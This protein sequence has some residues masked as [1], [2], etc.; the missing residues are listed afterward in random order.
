MELNHRKVAI[1]TDQN[2]NFDRNFERQSYR[3][4]DITHHAF[5]P[6]DN[7]NSY[8][9]MHSD[10]NRYNNYNYSHSKEFYELPK[11]SEELYQQTPNGYPTPQGLHLPINEHST[12]SLPLPLTPYSIPTTGSAPTSPSV[13]YEVGAQQYMP[14]STS[15]DYQDQLISPYS[16]YPNSFQYPDSMQLTPTRMSMKDPKYCE[17]RRKNN[18]ASKKSRA[19]KK[20]KAKEMES[21][22]HVLEEE[23][24]QLRVRKNELEQD[25]AGYKQLIEKI[26]AADHMECNTAVIQAFHQ[27][28]E[29]QLG[30][31]IPE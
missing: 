16:Q 31:Q 17:R 6:L 18:E 8:L 20:E 25:L 4:L 3:G 7:N 13:G 11:H 19:K 10:A 27:R 1:F 14:T 26:Q 2:D 28:K 5:Q 24:R 23:N 12:T 29:H 21:R 9:D 30:P 15:S 22:A